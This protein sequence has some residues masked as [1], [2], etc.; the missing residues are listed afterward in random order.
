[1]GLRQLRLN[2]DD[3]LRK[4]ANPVKEISASTIALLDDM[5][6]T[7]H[8]KNGVGLAAPQVGVLR[9]VA[10]VEVDEVRYE[11]INPVIADQDGEWESDEACLSVP[12]YCGDVVRPLRITVEAMN[13]DGDSIIVEAEEYLASVFCHEI[14]HLDGVLYLDKALNVRP[15]EAD[16]DLDSD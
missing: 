11:L 13:R 8:D 16:V 5:W 15:Y 10:I 12:G 2:G 1:M 7:L 9:R 6:D 14:D 4:K 3:I